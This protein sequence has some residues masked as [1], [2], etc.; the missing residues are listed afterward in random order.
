M[1]PES[2]IHASKSAALRFAVRLALFYIAL[3][4]LSGIQ[5]PFFPLWLRAT[6]IDS[7]W[8]GVISAVPAVARF[9]T[10]PLIA[11]LAERRGSL[12]RALIVTTT[13]TTFGFAWVG[14]QHETVAVFLAFVVT[15]CA[16]T[17]ILPL[18]DAYALRGMVR[19][20]INYGPVRL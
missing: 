15:A 18:T 6:G 20:G 2:L 7:S 9:T 4:G 5:L 17:P 13:L 12:R 16:W 11:S 10:L 3:F 1:P 19:Y 14:T 8:I